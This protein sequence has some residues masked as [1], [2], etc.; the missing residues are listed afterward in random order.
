MLQARRPRL[1]VHHLLAISDDILRDAVRLASERVPLRREPDKSIDLLDEACSLVRVRMPAEPA[2]PVRRLAA[3]RARLVAEERARID[4]L[5][6]IDRAGLLERLSYGTFR[7]FEEMGL[8]MEKLFTGQTT[9]RPRPEAPEG[10]PPLQEPAV[11]LA[12]VYAQRLA[13]DD[14]LREALVAAGLQLTTADLEAVVPDL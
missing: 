11:R 6:D 1:E 12:E 14:A 7:A 10:A 9:P 8:M 2:E 13:V 4:E 5:F 3:E